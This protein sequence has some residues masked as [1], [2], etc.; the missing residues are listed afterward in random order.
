M[1]DSVGVLCVI[2]PGARVEVGMDRHRSKGVVEAAVV[3]RGSVVRYRIAWFT[4]DGVRNEAELG[5]EEF[6]L[7]TETPKADP[8]LKIGFVNGAV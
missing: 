3:G 5:R 7:S 6:S 2:E 1:P 4:D 8:T